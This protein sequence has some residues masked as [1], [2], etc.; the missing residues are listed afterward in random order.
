MVKIKIEDRADREER[1]EGRTDEGGEKV[2][3][4]YNDEER[5]GDGYDGGLLNL[6]RVI[7]KNSS[8]MLCRNE[9]GK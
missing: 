8:G 3:C 1:E 5:E 7:V 4:R 9:L 2:R 6:W